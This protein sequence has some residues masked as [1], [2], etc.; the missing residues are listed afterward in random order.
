MT[1]TKK[2]MTPKTWASAKAVWESDDREGYAWIVRE[3]DLPVSRA[4]VSKRAKTEGWVKR[5]LAADKVTQKVTQVTHNS[6]SVTTGQPQAGR[7][8]DYKPEYDGL[9][10]RLMLLGLTRLQLAE[11]L[12]VS[13]RTIYHWCEQHPSFLQSIRRGALY[14]DAEVAESL[15][16][17][18]VGSV[19]PDQHIALHEG[20]AVVTPFDKHLPPDPQSMRFWLN[21]RKPELWRNKVEFTESPVI[22]MIDKEHMDKIYSVALKQAEEQR[23]AM[24]GRA[25]RL[26]LVLDSDKV[27]DDDLIIDNEY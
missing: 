13:E 8:T 25:E 15:F 17:R 10:Y 14:A 27:S 18:A 26:G 3:L 11:A 5:V 19:L 20:A 7:P 1:T 12:D 16:N 6:R 2:K 22:T 9:A 4:A 21:N 24:L 23:N